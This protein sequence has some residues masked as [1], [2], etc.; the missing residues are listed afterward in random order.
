MTSTC[1]V[2]A[3][4]R[5]LYWVCQEGRRLSNDMYPLV[6]QKNDK[7]IKEQTHPLS[8]KLLWIFTNCI[9]VTHKL[10]KLGNSSYLVHLLHFL[11][12]Y[13]FLQLFNYLSTHSKILFP[14][15]FFSNWLNDRDNNMW[16]STLVN[17]FSYSWPWLHV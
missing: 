16:N 17:F 6:E 9:I 5:I 3:L 2:S 10:G 7:H 4:H 1:T 12:Q 11:A 13:Y 15:S 8:S 14:S